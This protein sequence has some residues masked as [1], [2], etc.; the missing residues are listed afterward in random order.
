MPRIPKWVLALLAVVALA[1]AAAS[2]YYAVLL[3]QLSEW[4]V[5]VVVDGHETTFKLG[6]LEMLSQ[7]RNITGLGSVRAVALLKLLQL[8]GYTDNATLVHSLKAVGADGYSTQLDNA[9]LYLTKACIV[10]AE[11]GEADWGPARLVLESLSRKL[12]VKQL[13]RVEAKTGPWALALMVDNET[14]KVARLDELKELAEDVEGVGKAV[15]LSKLL[16][17]SGV[18]AVDVELVEFVGVD[19]YRSAWNGSLIPNAYIVLVPEPEVA[20]HGPL[21]GVVVGLPKSAWVHHLVAVNVLVR[22]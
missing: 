17:L 10:L 1:V 12:W 7:P 11:S 19:G 5:L 16:A 9:F 4:E 6:E 22:G 3:P 21:R 14:R 13:V 20:R 18:S 15:P 2:V 8:S